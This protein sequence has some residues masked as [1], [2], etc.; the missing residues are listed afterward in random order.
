MRLLLLSDSQTRFSNLPESEIMMD[1][2]V[3]AAQKHRPDIIIHGG[4]AKEEYDPVSTLVIKFW[5]RSIRRIK[6]AGFRIVFLKGNHD[7]ISQSTT[8]QDWLSILRAA[9]A[10]TVS[11]PRTKLVNGELIGFLPYTG[12][13][14]QEIEWAKQLGADRKKYGKGAS[15]LIFHN[16][17]AGAMLNAAGLPASGNSPEDLGMEKWTICLGGHLHQHQQVEGTNAWYIGSP[18]TQDWGEVNSKKGHLLVDV[19]PT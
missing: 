17:L 4:D 16:E 18:F 11:L 14:K 2:L 19:S 9:G 12:D 5:V 1:E 10:E 13:K 8:T 7:R 3:A 15:A 6:D